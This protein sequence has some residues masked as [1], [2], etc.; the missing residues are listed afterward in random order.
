[1]AGK[2]LYA[3]LG[4]KNDAT[5]AEIKKAYR[6]LARKHHPDVN[7]GNKE[8]E[9]N[10]KK[11]SEAHDVLSDPEK[12]KIYDE[13]GEEGLRAGFDP[14]QARQFRQWQQAGRSGR[15]T[16]GPGFSAEY[17][18]DQDGTRYS[19]FEDMFSDIFGGGAQGRGPSKGRDI[20]S[21]LEIDFLTAID[22]GT[23]RVTLQTSRPCPR[24]SGTGRVSTGSEAVC[25]TCGGTGQTRVAQGPY[26][27]S[28]TCPDCGGTGRSGE[29]CPECRGAG[30]V[31]STETIDVTIPAGVD[32]GSKIRLAGKGEPGRAGGPPGDLFIIM[33]VR[34]HPVFKREGDSLQVSLPVTIGEAMN[35]AEVTVPTPTGP[36]ELKI[37]PGTRSG[38]RL[39][40][41]GKGVPNLKTKQRGNMF[42]TISIQIPNTQ[43][44]E[45]RS[46]ASTLDRFYDGDVRRE[47][48][49]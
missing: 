29:P 13:F 11:I 23:T 45:A 26:N 14:G 15:T 20:E 32:E 44:P 21:Y 8:A 42:V 27:F 30:S 49:L 3:A 6:K 43:D 37:P 36:V 47:I 48:R 18:T 16:G 39:R 33:R 9:E 38:Q 2:D 7:P 34:P 10:F 4:V 25:R 24:C 1:M 22:G 5:A 40:L 17:F 12:R 46:A 31:P 28:Q 35:G 19:G 41:K